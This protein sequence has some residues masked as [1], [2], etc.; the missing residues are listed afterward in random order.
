MTAISKATRL[1]PTI[2]IMPGS[3]RLKIPPERASSSGTIEFMLS[4]KNFR[5]SPIFGNKSPHDS[6]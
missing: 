6:M 4:K 3:G 5:R 2:N 1:T